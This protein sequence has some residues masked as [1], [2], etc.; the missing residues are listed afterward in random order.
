MR[1]LRRSRD[2][3]GVGRSFVAVRDTRAAFT[4]QVVMP[5]SHLLPISDYFTDLLTSSSFKTDPYRISALD[6]TGK[7]QAE[8]EVK[9]E[10]DGNLIQVLFFAP[11]LKEAKLGRGKKDRPCRELCFRGR[12]PPGSTSFA[13]VAF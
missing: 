6:V 5:G 4:P 10:A 13:T 12:G 3:R 2:S 8:K 1:L 9:T 11:Y 7:A